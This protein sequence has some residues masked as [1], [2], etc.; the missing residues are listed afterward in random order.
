[1]ENLLLVGFVKEKYEVQ[2]E[3]QNYCDDNNHQDNKNGKFEF[4]GICDE[5]HTTID[6]TDDNNRWLTEQDISYLRPTR[7]ND[8]FRSRLM[9]DTSEEG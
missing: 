4:N 7:S 1:L 9:D 5:H 6:S 8:N 3:H 2:V